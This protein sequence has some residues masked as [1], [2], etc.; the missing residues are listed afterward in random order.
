VSLK[1][2][3]TDALGRPVAARRLGSWLRDALPRRV[4]GVVSVALLSDRAVRELNRTFRGIDRAT[5]VLSFPAERR[6][7]PD[8][9][10]R[11]K[12]LNLGPGDR[13][14]GP[15][16]RQRPLGDIAIAVGTARR[17]ARDQGH[18]LGTELRVLALH[19]VLHLLGYDHET[20]RGRMQRVE[21]RLRR[22]A[23]L[24]SGLI[25]RRSAGVRR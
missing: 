2:S 9:K 15:A 10:P 6:E 4:S 16:G 24:P 14:L 5:D 23:G 18:S 17:Q 20:D 12:D 11:G 21:E 25:L 8:S 19:G 7:A 13:G 1:V 22:R 3:V